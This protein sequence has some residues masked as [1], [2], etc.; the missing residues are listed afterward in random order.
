V[1]AAS[2]ARATG[3]SKVSPDRRS[4]L[5]ASL[6]ADGGEAGVARAEQ[7][8]GGRLGRRYG[9]ELDYLDDGTLTAA[10]K[11]RRVL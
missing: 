1:P 6:L 5:R 9:G 3:H 7:R 4:G 2:S 11:A 8:E 10:L